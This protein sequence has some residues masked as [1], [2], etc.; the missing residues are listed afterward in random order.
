MPAK[1][2]NTNRTNLRFNDEAIDALERGKK[3]AFG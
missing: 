3:H 1:G 2:G